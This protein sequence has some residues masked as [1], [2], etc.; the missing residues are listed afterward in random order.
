[1]ETLPA[2][3][4]VLLM[5][6]CL[7]IAQRLSA[8]ALATGSGQG[9]AT[10]AGTR[11]TSIALTGLL[12]L[13]VV[14]TLFTW[15]GVFTL[16]RTPAALL[17]VAI[18]YL[19]TRVLVPIEAAA[20]PAS[21]SSS[22]RRTSIA[23]ALTLA[24][25][26][27][28]APLCVAA[29]VAVTAVALSLLQALS[30]VDVDSDNMWYHLPMVAGWLQTGSI[31][32]NPA[33]PVMA[34]TYPGFHEALIAWISLPFGHEHLSV[35][36]GQWQLVTFGLTIAA[37][38][39]RLGVAA[40][41]ACAIVAYV[42]SAPQSALATRGTDLLFGTALL[43]VWLGLLFWWD[44][45]RANDRRAARGWA[46]ALGACAGMLVATKYSG[47]G[48]AGAA[49]AAGIAGC[50]I[51]RY[52]RGP[53]SRSTAASIAEMAILA[54]LCAAVV[55]GPWYVRNTLLYGNPLYPAQML[56]P[57]GMALAGPA[58]SAW[59]RSDALGMDIAPLVRQWRH[60]IQAF[61]LLFPV[62][63]VLA[64][65][66]A[67]LALTR[68]GRGDSDGE[69][70][71]ILALIALIPICFVLFLV[72]PFTK[73]SFDF[74][75]NMR[76]LVGWF[77]LCALA[78]GWTCQRLF[79]RATAAPALLFTAGAIVNLRQWTRWW[80]LAF[81]VM[82]A[83][84]LVIFLLRRLARTEMAR[85]STPQVRWTMKAGALALTASVLIVFLAGV[86]QLRTRQ[87]YSPDRGYRDAPSSRGW[88]AMARHVHANIG[89]EKIAVIGDNRFF[90][91]YGDRLNNRPF[92]VPADFLLSA[93]S[94]SVEEVVAVVRRERP[95]YVV[96]F[97]TISARTSVGEFVFGGSLGAR[98]VNAH[99]EL[100][101]VAYEADGA[102]LLRVRL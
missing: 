72:Q 54:G 65:G 46:M 57:G 48:Y 60:F 10:G 38:L 75:Y 45:C 51:D 77:G 42:L 26:R 85:R 49:G 64:F 14:G 40:G 91:L 92:F 47:V 98:L 69:S 87:Q 30:Y 71:H 3:T 101:S 73:P 83:F 37:L 36:V 35:L 11:L 66:G 93:P 8:G 56:L 88:G 52:R 31:A 5:L 44:A 1:M 89:N 22:D 55:A 17:L 25:G 12:W 90:P 96:C 99:P 7:G 86:S 9:G 70:W 100:F 43:G 13:V 74:N 81:G 68:R 4:T 58:T 39:A 80:F 67:A 29:A 59:L 78:A 84:G 41:L 15:L 2:A 63:I 24:V 61:G 79:P 23:E 62:L 97:N 19:A 76:F 94:P 28:D 34:R 33:I 21:V 20:A 102:Y 27:V 50:L 95:G 16:A 18:A 6:G 82:A 53:L 32:P